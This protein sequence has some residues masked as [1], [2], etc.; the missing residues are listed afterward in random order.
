MAVAVWWGFVEGQVRGWGHR[1]RVSV[2]GES[3]GSDRAVWALLQLPYFQGG[4]APPPGNHPPYP[5]LADPDPKRE[6]HSLYTHVLPVA[7]CQ[8]LLWTVHV[9]L[10]PLACYHQAAVQECTHRGH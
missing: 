2:D 4:S 5:G 6:T 1:G 9:Q 3:N 8:R 7:E 10:E